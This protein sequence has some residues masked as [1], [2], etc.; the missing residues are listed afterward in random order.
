[1]HANDEEVNHRDKY[2]H[3]LS[4]AIFAS[5]VGVGH[6]TENTNSSVNKL[7]QRTTVQRRK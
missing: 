1:M 5:R 7:K 4:D 2:R 6:A 3:R